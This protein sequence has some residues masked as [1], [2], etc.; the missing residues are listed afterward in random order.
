LYAVTDGN[1]PGANDRCSLSGLYCEGGGEDSPDEP[2]KHECEDDEEVAVLIQRGDE[3]SDNLLKNFPAVFVSGAPVKC[4]PEIAGF[5]DTITI[6]P[7]ALFLNL[8]LSYRSL[9]I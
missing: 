6:C 3:K 9:L 4:P 1:L 7:S 2:C 8:Y 5:R